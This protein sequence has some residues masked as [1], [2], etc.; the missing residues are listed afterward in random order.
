M[1]SPNAGKPPKQR[2]QYQVDVMVETAQAK[3]KLR[4]LETLLR[5]VKRLASQ[6]ENAQKGYLSSKQMKYAG[7]LKSQSEKA[8]SYLQS[9]KS[10]LDAV[11]A[12]AQTAYM[13]Y[14]G[15]DTKKE[16]K[17]KHAYTQAK[18]RSD[19]LNNLLQQARVSQ[20]MSNQYQSQIGE[21]RESNL[22]S[23]GDS[24]LNPLSRLLPFGG[25]YGAGQYVD[26]SMNTQRQR[27]A[28][29][30]KYGMKIGAYGNNFS[31][32][33]GGTLEDL[34]N[35][36]MQNGYTSQQT[37]DTA[38]TLL[39]L[40]G[41]SGDRDK[42]NQDVSYG[43]QFGRT[44]GVDPNLLAGAGGLL[45]Q[46]G[47]VKE[48]DQRR[49]ADLLA[50]SIKKT[51][52][53]GREEELIRSTVALA[54][55]VGSSMTQM[56]PDQL[57][58]VAGAQS[59][60]GENNSTLKGERGASLLSNMDMGIKNS[61]NLGNLL[62]GLGTDKRWQG[63]SG[64][65]DLQIQRQKG[66]SD[67]QNLKDMLAGA[68]KIK[69]G[70]SP[71]DTLANQEMVLAQEFGWTDKMDVVKTLNRN[72]TLDKIGGMKGK[73][74]TSA[75]V[76]YGLASEKE[77]NELYNSS[78]AGKQAVADTHREERANTMGTWA[79]N[80]GTNIMTQFNRLPTSVQLGGM[81]AAGIGGGSVLRG[82]GG[83]IIRSLGSNIPPG[84][85]GIRG[86]LTRWARTAPVTSGGDLLNGANYSGTSQPLSGAG[87]I[88]R[89][90]W[91]KL[92]PA[93]GGWRGVPETVLR[94]SKSILSSGTDGMKALGKTMLKPVPLVGTA[95]GMGLDMAGGNSFGKSLFKGA[96]SLIG[97]A[98]G[99]G[100]AGLAGG[101]TGGVGLLASGALIGGGSVAGAQ[102][103]GWLWDKLH[104]KNKSID[105]SSNAG[106]Y[107]NSTSDSSTADVQTIN[108]K[109]INIESRVRDM[110][111]DTTLSSKNYNEKI[112]PTSTPDTM[113][114]HN[115]SIS[116]KVEGMTVDNQ[117][118]VS[119]GITDY[120]SNFNSSKAGYGLTTVKTLR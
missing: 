92:G 21:M 72:G 89:N 69:G 54:Q 33:N 28:Q 11:V 44:H 9:K 107:V 29:A 8:M 2:T 16:N 36:G 91:S 83:S 81:L 23:R 52:M 26:S 17:L 6:G 102:G 103:A 113:V 20:N 46:M 30:A 98:I 120:I 56:A 101:G 99:T 47:A 112:G 58:A 24:A 110:S 66:L 68:R 70:A 59:I 84:P 76:S 10:S 87:N 93:E 41:T 38:S 35:T 109:N 50:G 82:A 5:S 15:T 116:G 117:S 119:N 57:G 4:E 75:L 114:Q 97:G 90:I 12:T 19:N 32:I 3:D 14:T 95:V 27:Q 77:A 18:A 40:Q 45:S 64:Y 79:G 22:L 37:L 25:I 63:I 49:F 51:N 7:G 65:Q 108:A 106:P 13:D 62:M 80:V 1:A 118:K 100:A 78:M 86:G 42:I 31:G 88:A 73:E 60:L 61:D 115:I 53:N 105:P 94:N 34:Q 55:Q 104:G 74:Y 67:P 111:S 39:S 85:G 71:E 43:Q 96:G 48:G